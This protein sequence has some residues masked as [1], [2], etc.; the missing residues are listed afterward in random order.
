MLLDSLS[1][2]Y[3]LCY[4]GLW[5]VLTRNLQVVDSVELVVLQDRGFKLSDPLYATLIE[6]KFNKYQFLSSISWS[7]T[8]LRTYC[9][10]LSHVL[11][12]VQDGVG[13]LSIQ[14]NPTDRP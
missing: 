6:L 9:Y 12:S 1:P 5:K 13:F 10:M 8:F 4:R 7:F 11:C 2:I 14:F 3:S